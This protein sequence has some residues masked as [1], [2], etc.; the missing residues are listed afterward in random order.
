MR[1]TCARTPSHVWRSVRGQRAC[2]CAVMHQHHNNR[3][4]ASRHR[5]TNPPHTN[6]HT[7][8]ELQTNCCVRQCTAHNI[9]VIIIVV[10]L[11][12]CGGYRVHTHTHTSHSQVDVLRLAGVVPVTLARYQVSAAAGAARLIES[13]YMVIVCYYAMPCIIIRAARGARPG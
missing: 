2:T 9:I 6:T 3:V 13:I 10:A 7:H 12:V 5:C 11:H 8:T 4:R 1:C